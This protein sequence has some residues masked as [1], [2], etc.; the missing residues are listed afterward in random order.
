MHQLI[1]YFLACYFLSFNIFLNAGDLSLDINYESGI[2]LDSQK[3]FIKTLSVVKSKK[4]LKLLLE[5]QDWI[6]S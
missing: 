4:E 1:K 2:Q 5:N 3:A 6:P